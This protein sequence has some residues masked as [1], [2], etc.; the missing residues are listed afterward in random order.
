[1][2]RYYDITLANATGQV[3][4]FTA[5]GN[6]FTLGTG[7]TTFSSLTNGINNPGALNIEFDIPVFNYNTPQGNSHITVWGVGLGMI[8]QAAQ[9]AGASITVSGGM[10][11]GLP[12]ATAAAS[13][14]GILIQ[15]TVYQSYGNW[16]GNNQT[17]DLVINSGIAALD[18]NISFN[19]IAGQTLASAIAATLSQ[20]FPAPTFKQSINIGPLFLPSTEPGLYS[21]FWQ[22]ASYINDISQRYG[23]PIYGPN[24]AGVN[25]MVVGNTIFAYDGTVPVTP[26]QLA[27][28][29]MIGQPTWIDQGTV[30]FKT[31]MRSDFALGT[32]FTFPQ[33]VQSPYA[34]TA[35][36]AAVP[37][38]LA[39]NKSIFQG[40]F[41]VK[42][43]HHF[44]NFRQPDADAWATAMIA[45]A[46]P[47]FA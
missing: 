19:W 45:N 7:G 25:L 28:Q 11:P 29:D 39:G 23:K 1:M 3:Y 26:K 42:E 46:A 43:L 31:V 34:L 22:F 32:Q 21:N 37:G 44:A 4:Q 41:I 35:P 8:G 2:G 30:S 14:A 47:S 24:Y 17:L 10:K 5:D 38:G 6:G 40:T 15:G 27:F 18:Q 12:L 9:L 36:T 13:Q 20:A 33:G 16:Q